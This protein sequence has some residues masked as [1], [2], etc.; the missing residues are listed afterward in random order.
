MKE[1]PI[2]KSHAP[3]SSKLAF[4]ATMLTV[5]IF[6]LPTTGAAQE[7]KPVETSP[8][9]TTSPAVKQPAPQMVSLYIK[10][11][12]IDEKVGGN[13]TIVGTENKHAIYK[14]KNGKMFY[15]DPQ[16]GDQ[17]FLSSKQYLKVSMSAARSWPRKYQGQLTLVG[18]D[19]AGNVMQKNAAGDTFY[20]DGATGDMVFVK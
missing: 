16:T 2:K 9:I 5:P 11:R 10:W 12:D 4:A 17:K 6:A 19:A 1:P 18:V 13:V 20:L 14:D 7:M 3:N 15:I 8:A